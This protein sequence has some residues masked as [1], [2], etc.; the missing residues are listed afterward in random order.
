ME[1]NVNPYYDDFEDTNGPRESNYMRILF[2]PEYAVQARELTQIQTIIQNQIKEFGN[3]I[4]KDGSPVHGGHLSLDTNAVALKLNQQY[5]SVDVN[6][7]DFKDQI[8]VEYQSNSSE[9]SAHIIAVDDGQELPTLMVKY[10]TN[11]F[12]NAD[13]IQS[14]SS[15]S[16][17]AE[18]NSNTAGSVVSINEGVFYVNGFFVYVPPQS[19]VLEAYSTTP[20]YKIGLEIEEAIVDVSQDSSLADPAQSSFN[21]QAPG[22][23]R[24]QFNLNLTKRPLD[25]T[26]DSKFFELL[27]VENGI[28]TKQVTYPLYS[29]I[30]KTLARRTYDESGDYTVKPFKIGTSANTA[31]TERFILELSAGKAYV[32]GYEFETIS[33]TKFDIDKART[34]SESKDHDLSLQYGNY[35]SVSN[36]H[37]GN[38]ANLNISEF[39]ELDLHLVEGAYI[40]TTDNIDIDTGVSANYANTK[41]GTARV[42]NITY[43]SSD[44]Y[45]LYLTNVNISPMT[46]NNNGTS[47]AQNE[48]LL[49]PTFST[50]TNA[51]ANVEITILSGTSAGDSRRIISSG[52]GSAEVDRN[53]SVKLDG[54]SVVSYN[55]SVKD[56]DSITVA[57]ASY[58]GNRYYHQDLT[59]NNYPCMNVDKSSRTIAGNSY[60]SL[61]NLNRYVFPLPESYV[62]R[63][64]FSDL[65]YYSRKLIGKTFTSGVTAI[66]GGG[67]L[68]SGIETYYYG[69]N[70]AALSEEIYNQNILIAVRNNN[71]DTTYSNGQILVFGT[72]INSVTRNSD[73]SIT[74]A[75]NTAAN[76]DVD[77][78]INVKVS[79]GLVSVGNRLRTKTLYGN[80]SNTALIATD[81][82]LNADIS[83]TSNVK[84]DTAN[85]H[86]WY[87]NL[88]EVATTPGTKQSLY[89]PDAFKIIKIYDSGDVAQQPT[90]TNAID[91]TENYLF[92]TGQTDNMYDHA[93]IVLKDSASAPRGQTVVMLQY[94]GHE[95]DNGFFNAYSYSQDVYDNNIIPVYT[96][97]TSGTF[98]LRDAIDFRPTRELGNP[99]FSL[100]GLDTINPDLPMTITYSSYLP[101]IDKVI[102]TQ[103]KEFKILTGIPSHTPVEPSD[104]EDGMTLYSV[105]IP[106]YTFDTRDIKFKYYDHKRYTMSDIGNLEKRISQVE[107]YTSLSL[108][109]N[110]ARSQSILYEDAVLQKEKYGIVVDQFDGFNIADNKNSDLV[111]QISFSSL[112]PYKKTNIVPF[113]L[114]SATGQYDSNGRTYSLAYGETPA[115]SQ[116]S[117]TKS[118]NIQPYLFAQYKGKTKLTPEIDYWFSSKLSP[119][120]IASPTDAVISDQP[121]VETET[122]PTA[123]TTQNVAANTSLDNTGFGYITWQRDAD[124]SS[125]MSTTN[126]SEIRPTLSSSATNPSNYY[127]LSGIGAGNYGGWTS[128]GSIKTINL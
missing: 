115:V 49:P 85:G 125:A 113:K 57:P 33:T 110:K 50:S 119:E 71:G 1:F 66:N 37:F 124:N 111:C 13:V 9:K 53:F 93:T 14:T 96:S 101:R 31:N 23:D 55:Y 126:A 72:D 16:L 90:S 4:F 28:I 107:Y 80:T 73:D 32:K 64:N 18:V 52:S 54:T 128:F 102:A 99:T 123:G 61:T 114:V 51:Y 45:Y 108:L 127:V 98:S 34:Y 95:N 105:F 12:E 88:S 20:T 84:I 48:I 70:G 67:G 109:E 79:T 74:V 41:I 63:S 76:I 6:P 30:E 75:L 47:G 24:Y 65:T 103:N 106:P 92:D 104:S 40:N 60:F 68:E 118:V 5:N 100:I 27:R 69:T 22:A 25:S 38:T 83:V 59:S 19:I 117:A 26:D 21:Y 94:F 81:S 42:R 112:K 58:G 7:N 82:Y 11:A 35:I 87:T 89:I 91:I 39:A 77:V 2:K 121:P 97:K 86:V 10:L 44:R 56:V 78:Y 120:V 36:L 116:T 46:A 17:V 15:S 43:A 122:V 3:H 29:D 62:T 8:I